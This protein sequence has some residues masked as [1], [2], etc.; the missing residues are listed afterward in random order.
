MP[1]LRELGEAEVV[2]RLIA[3]RSPAPG[4]IVDAGDDAAIV[5]PEESADLVVTTDA[6]VEGSHFL[7]EW[8][9][10]E[11]IGARLATAC[12]SDLAAMG[13]SPRWG[14]L[15][16]GLDPGREIE[17]L[18]ALEAGLARAL[19]REG[20][21][22]VGGNLSSVTGP[23]WYDLTLIGGVGRGRAWTR[24]GARPGDLVAV[25]GAPGRAGAGSRLARSPGAAR[26]EGWGPLLDAWIR[27]QPRI[28]LA[29]AL[30][31]A[32]GVMAAIDV[33][34]GFAGDLERLCEASG[35]GA[36][37]DESSWPLD[38]ALARAAAEL[39][40]THD[41]LRFGPSDDYELLLAIA[42]EAKP[43]AEAAA[44]A[45]GVPLWFVGTFTVAPGTLIWNRRNGSREPIAARGWDHFAGR[46]T[47]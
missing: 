8:M 18:L 29:R 5:R 20:A 35:T 6:F 37:I 24:R 17:P 9:S 32:G 33:S 23:E 40:L 16:M 27:P 46:D 11:E 4:V 7:R 39:G 30:A 14:L 12:L 31:L 28:R 15:S 42:P 36:A 43:A 19:E 10:S 45:E 3:T 1:T 13:A 38:E 21:A 47:F 34:D 44:R 26:V 41:A 22:L 25:S 2:R